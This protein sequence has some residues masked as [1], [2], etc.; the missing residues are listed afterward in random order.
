MARARCA[1][2]GA[3]RL[4]KYNQLINLNCL[5]SKLSAMCKIDFHAKA[6]KLEEQPENFSREHLGEGTDFDVDLYVYKTQGN[7]GSLHV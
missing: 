6:Q 5:E 3:R 7:R 1:H 4:T 2:H